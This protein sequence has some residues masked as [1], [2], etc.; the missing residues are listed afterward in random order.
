MIQARDNRKNCLVYC[1]NVNLTAP[2]VETVEQQRRFNNCSF[3][4]YEDNL[5]Q[6][7][8]FLLIYNNCAHAWRN[9]QTKS[10]F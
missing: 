7:N 4:G 9:V 2:E 10:L 6:I 8:G 1:V 3:Q 5:V